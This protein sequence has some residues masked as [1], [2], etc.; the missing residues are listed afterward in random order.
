MLSVQKVLEKLCVPLLGLIIFFALTTFAAYWADQSHWERFLSINWARVF[1]LLDLREEQTSATWFSSTLFLITAMG[2]ALLGWGQSKQYNIHIIERYLFKLASL[3]LCALSVD[4]TASIH[5]T[6]GIWFERQS[7]LLNDT[8]FEYIS[9]ST[10]GFSWLLIFAPIFL[11]GL[12]IL[13]ILLYRLIKVIPDNTQRTYAYYYLIFAVLCLPA[14]L[15]LEAWQ[16]HFYALGMI[17]KQLF[18]PC[19]EE[20]CELLGMYF[21]FRSVLITTKFY[22]L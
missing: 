18:A 3:A 1:Q 2:F 19:L 16:A 7:T 17:E 12:A 9:A 11:L 15:V 4:E 8:A 10:T 5:E 13:V 20:T 14:V 21:L 6:I 22:Q